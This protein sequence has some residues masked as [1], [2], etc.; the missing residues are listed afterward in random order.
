MVPPFSYFQEACASTP[1][2]TNL[3]SERLVA[4]PWLGV[5]NCRQAKGGKWAAFPE[6]EPIINKQYTINHPWHKFYCKAVWKWTQRTKTQLY[7]TCSPDDRINC[8]PRP[9]KNNKKTLHH[10]CFSTAKHTQWIKIVV[11]DLGAKTKIG[12]YTTF[13]SHYIQS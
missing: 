7:Q 2:T 3:D 10:L 1:T 9:Q 13:C 12:N 6:T 4:M 8:I 11:T 5:V